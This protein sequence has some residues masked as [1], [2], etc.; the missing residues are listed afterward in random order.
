MLESTS[1]T[2]ANKDIV[3]IA[4]LQELYRSLHALELAYR[5]QKIC[6]YKPRTWSELG[7]RGKQDRFHRSTKPTRLVLGDNRSGK[8]VSG[9]CEAIAHSLGYRPWLPKDDP[10]HVVRLGN[11]E[12]IPVPNVG[13]VIA[14]TYQQAIK[15]TIFPKF[16]E[17]APLGFY[18]VK[19]DTRGIPV[20]LIWN[21]GSITYFMSDDQDDMAFE[22]P[23]GHWFWADEPPSYNKYVGLCRGLVD[24]SGHHWLT[25]TPLS[26][27]WIAD[28]IEARANDP[29]GEVDVYEFS[30]WD[31][32]VDNGGVLPRK[33]INSFISALRDDQKAARVGREWLAYSGRVFKEWKASP[34]FWVDPFEIPAHWPRVELCDPHPR[35]PV[36]VMWMAFSPDGQRIIYRDLFD[37]ELRTIDQVSERIKKLEGWKKSGEDYEGR[38]KYVR[39]DDTEN[40][41]SRMIDWSSRE[42]ERT[43]GHTVWSKFVDNDLPHQL[44][45]KRNKDAGMDAIHEALRLPY[46]WSR[47]GVIV[48]NNCQHVKR[49]FMRFVWSDWSS[50]K[51]RDI[52]GEKQEVRKTDDDFID[53]IRYSFQSGLSYQML[54]NLMREMRDT[55]RRASGGFA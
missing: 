43:S 38:A 6:F 3:L 10:N 53:L 12:P 24:F 33:A 2:Q 50:S 28:V 47:P 54:R 52:M 45:N 14:Q 39:T 51:Q 15:Q 16:Q 13:R 17:W 20:E 11:G 36:A 27:M 41:V 40:V 31:N 30:I 42:D 7:E 1:T 37:Q 25:L 18:K 19:Y 23:S 4:E 34:P 48:F 49:N 46:E 35:K 5:S 22:G 32:C 26:Q 9:V 55:I 21:N 29:D 8:S 44:A